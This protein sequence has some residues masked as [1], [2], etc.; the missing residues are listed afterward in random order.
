MNDFLRFKDGKPKA[1]SFSYDD[2]VVDDIRLVEMF[3]KYGL[4]GTFNVNS[5]LFSSNAAHLSAEVIRDLYLKDG[6]E[7]ACHGLNHP[8][9][10]KLADNLALYEIM[11]DRRRLEALTG[12][13]IHGLAYPYGTTSDR[14]VELLKAAGI[15]YA[16][17]I[18]NSNNFDI[19][20]EWL[21]MKP[22][23]HHDSKNIFDL[24]DDFL[25][26]DMHRIGLGNNDGLFFN[27]WGHS[28]EFGRNNNWEHMEKVCEALS[29]HDE[30]WYATNIEVYRYVEAFR[31]LEFS[32][33][34]SLVYN[35]T[36]IDIWFEM[37]ETPYSP[38]KLIC[39][40]SGQTVALKEE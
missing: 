20:T 27:I 29:G 19:P 6:H 7:L 31:N 33:D 22:T 10:E 30:V 2:G 39:I 34:H 11:E 5:N 16:R 38:L 32:M 26:R 37:R 36:T 18:N 9:L 1:L 21:K 24:I 8:F 14:T 25:R 40:K 28:Y 15:F 4:K 23:C 12:T 17:T 13:I 3:N 35:P